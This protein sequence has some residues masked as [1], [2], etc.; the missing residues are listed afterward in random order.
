MAHD[1]DHDHEDSPLQGYFDWQ[2]NTLMLAYDLK[3]PLDR[4]DERSVQ[5]RRHDVEAEVSRLSLA[6]IPEIYRNDPALPWP[7]SVMMALTRATL[8]RACE[9][10]NL[11]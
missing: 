1:H 6:E 9:I 3:N 8:K 11:F 2:V 5:R 7:P 10:A 4:G